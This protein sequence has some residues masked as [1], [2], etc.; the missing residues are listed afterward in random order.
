MKEKGVGG[1][2]KEREKGVGGETKEKERRRR[3]DEVNVL[4]Q[5]NF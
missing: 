4:F 2:T 5:F 3:R 1:E